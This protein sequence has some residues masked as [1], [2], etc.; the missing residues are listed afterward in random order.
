M[1]YMHD[2]G[3]GW[4][5]LMAI[6]MIAFWALIIYGVVWLI[7]GGNTTSS[8]APPPATPTE[9]PREILDRRLASGELTIEEYHERRE[10]LEHNKEPAPA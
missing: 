7:R 3:W 5:F 10:A 9:T 4:E 8:T 6:G 1:F 2:I